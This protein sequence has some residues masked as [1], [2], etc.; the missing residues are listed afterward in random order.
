MK[1]LKK[2]LSL[3]VSSVFYCISIGSASG[4]PVKY[5][6]INGDSISGE[7]IQEESNSHTKVIMH[8]YLGKIEL[9]SSSIFN[10]KEKDWYSN[11]ELG[12]DGSST[13]SS[14]SMGYLLEVNTKYKTKKKEFNL[15]TKYA[16][17]KTS[18]SGGN[19]ITGINKSTTKARFD[20]AISKSFTSY[21]STNYEY[22]AL[23]KIGMNDISSSAGIAYKPIENSET[24][25]RLSAGPSIEWVDGGSEC[26]KDEHCGEIN[27]GVSLGADF[28]WNINQGLKLL[29]NNT[30]NRQL[31]ES[32]S[33]SNKFSSA[34]K[35]YPSSE[36]N[37][38]T[39]LS[40]EN[41][42]DHMKQPNNENIFHIK[43]G[44][45]F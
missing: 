5:K 43:L 40:Y 29:I 33:I 41:I 34:V 2:L 13:S 14:N 12:L 4:E 10:P 28:E 24:T 11:L 19:T 39:S 44:T 23:N 9:K 30:F 7:L 36:S 1:N 18:K 38:Y 6:L 22:N 15:G 37:L 42:Y 3:T 17:K 20:Q 32:I 31:S 8:K 45:D 21:I 16:F 35:F 27:P 25:V 26:S